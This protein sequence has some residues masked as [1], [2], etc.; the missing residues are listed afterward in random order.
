MVEWHWD[1]LN[2]Q[3]GTSAGWAAHNCTGSDGTTPQV[4]RTM[5]HQIQQQQKHIE[6]EVTAEIHELLRS[7]AEITGMTY[8][9]KYTQYELACIKTRDLHMVWVQDVIIWSPWRG[10]GIVQ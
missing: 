5:Q 2:V 8:K 4:H 7:A 9:C 6:V 10:R 1:R 3:T